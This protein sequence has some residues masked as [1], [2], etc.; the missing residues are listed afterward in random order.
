MGNKFMR[1]MVT[2]IVA[3]AMVMTSGVFA[4]A[5]SSPTTGKITTLSSE[6]SNGGKKITVTWKADKKAD[7]YIVKV[8]SMSKE[9]T[10][11]SA[12]FT[13]KAGT[14]YKV[15][16]TPVYGSN[17]GTSKSQLRWM[18]TTTLKSA[19][20]AGSKKVKLTWKKAS[21][22]T[23]Y[24]VMQYKSGKWVVV[25]T[26]KK[27]STTSTTVKVA[28]KGTA[29]FRVRAMKGSYYGIVSTTKSVKVK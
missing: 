29:K 19:K 20:A 13:T 2:L 4:F 5:A 1:R 15:S 9:V 18:R 27:G 7:K 12:T 28:K 16:V 6:G 23:G 11:T 14:K 8:G 24:K 26:I 25:K 22:A 10:G 17:N 21:G 3:L